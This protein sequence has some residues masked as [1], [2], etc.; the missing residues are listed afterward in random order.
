MLSNQTIREPRV[1]THTIFTA[2]PLSL[3]QARS[4]DSAPDQLRAFRFYRPS[5]ILN[6][7]RRNVD[8]DIDPVQQR[9]GNT[10]AILLHLRRTASAFSLHIAVVTARTRVHC[11]DRNERVVMNCR[12]P[13][14]CP[15]I[16]WI[17]VVSI[18]SSKPMGGRIDGMRLAII[19]LPEPGGPIINRL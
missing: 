17:L 8:V 5:Q 11:G 12:S 9:P 14:N 4:S 15:Q 6:I 10:S 16:L 18:A 2:Q 19:D 1:T 3:N 7:D 13:F